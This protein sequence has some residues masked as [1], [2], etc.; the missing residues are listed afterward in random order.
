MSDIGKEVYKDLLR[1]V[2][3]V[4]GYDS[5][6]VVHGGQSFGSCGAKEFV[7]SEL[8]ARSIQFVYLTP[9]GEPTV[10]GVSSLLSNIDD[11]S[12]DAIL[13]VGGGSVIDTAKL[14]KAFSGSVSEIDDLLGGGKLFTP[15]DVPIFVVP[16]L[17]GAGS[18]VT[19][20]A[21]V[22]SGKKK[23]SV[24]HEEL[25]PS[26]YAYCPEFVRLAPRKAIAASALVHL[27]RSSYDFPGWLVLPLERFGHGSIVVFDE[28]EDL[29]V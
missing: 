9:G 7:S 14:I 3:Q 5:V 15:L 19:H 12:F 6:L 20:F 17:V 24:V 22:Y 16:T 25:L 11:K 8:R 21:V 29:R 1:L 27:G 26:G 28:I 10:E 13:A 4:S 23:Y 2:K 18:E